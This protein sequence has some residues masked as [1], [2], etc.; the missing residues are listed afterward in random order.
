[1]TG[2]P[3]VAGQDINH[4]APRYLSVSAAAARIGVKAK[5]IYD[6]I[7]RGHLPVLRHGRRMICDLDDVYDAERDARERDRTGTAARRVSGP[8]CAPAP[9]MRN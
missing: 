2:R 5:V 7:D 6:W 9:L 1:M 8:A 3:P 4:D